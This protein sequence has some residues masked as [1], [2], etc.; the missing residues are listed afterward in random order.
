MEVLKRSLKFQYED[1]KKPFCIFWA[2]A[3]L[4][5]LGLNIFINVD[6]TTAFGM[7]MA[8][9]IFLL[10]D[11]ILMYS[12]T[13]PLM[14]G[15]GSTRKDF[16]ISSIISFFIL[17]FIMSIIQS[18]LFKVDEIIAVIG[19]KSLERIL[20]F[21]GNMLI[22]I[23]FLTILAFAFTAIF[24]IFAII[25]YKIGAWAWTL[26]AILLFFASFDLTKKIFIFITKRSTE[27]LL[28]GL[29][30]GALLLFEAAW[31][32]IKGLE[33]KKQG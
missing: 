2:I 31:P 5:Y 12:E 11:A 21:N 9:M 29:F 14:L 26:P 8:A 25:V 15:L 23:I 4:V 24:N 1:T 27:Q 22:T 6:T 3:L 33:V 13:F 7:V 10:V 19:G 16:Y 32:V 18:I 17:S 20:I 30:A 28:I